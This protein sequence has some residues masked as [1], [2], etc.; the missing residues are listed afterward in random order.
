MPY[1]PTGQKPG[2][3]RKEP[4]HDFDDLGACPTE[5][6]FGRVVWCGGIGV[7]L[8]ELQL[9]GKATR[10]FCDGVRATIRTIIACVPVERTYRAEDALR[11]DGEAASEKAK[12]QTE[13]T[14]SDLGAESLSGPPP[15][16]G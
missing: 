7:R 12:G 1:K 11:R 8:L 5:D 3:P 4:T 6:P 9:Q 15:R 10:D 2:R 14:I 16:V 13:Q